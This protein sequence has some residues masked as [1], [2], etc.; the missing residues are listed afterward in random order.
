ME[1]IEAVK[2]LQPVLEEPEGKDRFAIM[3][4]LTESEVS[5]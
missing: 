5:R 3:S 4:R 1:A 2:V